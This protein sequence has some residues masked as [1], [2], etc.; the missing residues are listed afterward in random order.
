MDRRLQSVAATHAV[1]EV[2]VGTRAGFIAPD[3]ALPALDGSIMSLSAQRDKVV[4][5]NLW[6]SWCGPCRA[7][8]QAINT[9][10][11]KH[12]GRRL[13]GARRQRDEPG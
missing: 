8:M 3:F 7:E 6:A 9:V 1:R 4:L 2:K 11:L 10:Y 13:R 12:R 5:V